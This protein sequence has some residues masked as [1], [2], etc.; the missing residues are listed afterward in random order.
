ME[1]H[2]DWQK[3]VDITAI[4]MLRGPM[5]NGKI[6]RKRL[7]KNAPVVSAAVIT[8]GLI[9]AWYQTYQIRAVSRSESALLYCS[10]Y[11]SNEAINRFA[12]HTSKFS[13]WAEKEYKDINIFQA[14]VPYNK[15]TQKR[16]DIDTTAL[17]K[18]FRKYSRS[19]GQLAN[20]F[21]YAIDGV[22]RGVF[23]ESIIRDCLSTQIVCF[24]EKYHVRLGIFGPKEMMDRWR[25][26]IA[27]GIARKHK[28]SVSDYCH[29]ATKEYWQD[30]GEECARC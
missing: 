24:R 8:L 19:F 21:D 18:K 17:A 13:A 16:K 26:F 11:L 3:R 12:S 14:G 9:A 7:R 10:L 25:K 6:T 23:D 27:E 5:L 29:F 20:Y 1:S 28:T 2:A 4:L 15:I 30:R 22:D